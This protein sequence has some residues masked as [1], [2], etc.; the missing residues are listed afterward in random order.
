VSLSAM[1][2]KWL[3]PQSPAPMLAAIVSGVL[4]LL[5]AIVVAGRGQLKTPDTLE[6]SLLLLLIPLLSPQGWDYVFL[7]ATPA[8][9]LLINDSAALPSGVRI[10][11]FAAIAVAGLTIFD[12]VGREAYAMFMQ[13]S[14][15]TV[16]MLV[17]AAAI[18]VLRFKRAA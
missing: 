3:G 4:L 11:A 6:A 8:V 7:I 12:L 5:T 16:C 10:A 15:V 14:I 1:F 13:L 2:A 17:E 18:V 9:M